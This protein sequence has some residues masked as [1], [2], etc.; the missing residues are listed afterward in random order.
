MNKK[1]SF[2]EIQKLFNPSEWDVG[3]ISAEGLLR[4]SL[5]PIKYKFHPKGF[6]FTNDIH[7]H[8]TTNTIILIR[9]GEN[10]NYQHYDEAINILEKSN[11]K[12]FFQVYTN[13]KEAAILAGLGVRARNSLVYSYKFGFDC[14]ICAIAFNDEIVDLPTNKRVNRTLWK[15]C[16]GCD[17]CIKAC[18]VGAI[19]GK[20]EPY[21]LNSDACDNF[22]GYGDHPNVPSVKKFWHENVYPELSKET[23]D[24]IK[25]I[26]DS[27]KMFGESLPWNKNGFVFDGQV[28]RK[29][30]EFVR[31]PFCKEC[32]VQPRCS[33]WN[34]KYPYHE[35]K[36][37]P[38][39]KPIKFISRAK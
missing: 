38:E 29:D 34:G 1:I 12:N 32:T 7:F 13:F 8:E 37:E 16:S 17:D 27:K 33:K 36:K 11:L 24:N 6:D 15:R 18:P 25:N 9:G 30:G 39:Y 14:L 26:F 5:M 31:V 2:N 10:W 4:C 3:V 19:H 28:I 35:E 21:W 22:I 20:E 23:V